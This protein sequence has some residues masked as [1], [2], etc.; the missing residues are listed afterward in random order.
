MAINNRYHIRKMA[1]KCLLLGM[2][3]SFL[4]S[5]SK[6]DEQ[7]PYTSLN[8][9]EAFSNP[10]RIEKAAIGMYDA[11]QNAEFLGGRALI[12]VDLRGN[13][14]NPAAY[15]GTVSTFNML[16]T[17]NLAFNCWAG[18]YRTIFET[19]YFTKNLQQ[20]E[21]VVGKEQATVYYGEAKFIRALCYFY[22]VNLYGQTYT[23]QADA[24]QLGVPLVLEAVKDGAEAIDPKNRIPR[25]TVKEVY[26]R[27]IQ[28]LNEAAAV[29]PASWGDD[30]FDHARATKGAVYAL[31][32][33]IY[34]YTHNYAKA[35]DYADSVLLS[36]AGYALDASPRAVFKDDFTASKERIF[37]VA[38]NTSDNPNTNN[39]IGQHYSAKG[40]GDI[41]IGPDYFAI[42]TFDT[43]KDGRK[44][45]IDK[46]GSLFYT[47]KYYTTNAVEAW[48]PVFRLAEIMLIKAEAL[49]NLSPAVDVQAVQLLNEVRKRAGAEELVPLT[50][51]ALIDNI[52]W[53][54]R[55]ELAF[56]GHGEF[57]FL[58]THRDIP[59]RGSAHPLQ[60]WNSDYVV[61]PIPFSETQRNPNLKQNNGYN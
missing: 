36:S 32:S 59:A 54:R 24:G 11:L 49:A 13:D 15:F 21:S 10:E 30:Y 43:T 55:I 57:D 1:G 2:A 34:L 44:Q 23:F 39:A 16:S 4:F 28:D 17:T 50:K 12:Y 6:V 60:K 56:E 26:D 18:G 37:S 41:T 31:L 51:Q 27:M 48:V 7:Q 47:N 29:L 8:P 40:R 3:A 33:R 52:L 61:F 46:V 5:C 25:N 42:P 22:L 53:E 14:V 58:R 20:H 9:D 38:M 19:N 45:L 35:R